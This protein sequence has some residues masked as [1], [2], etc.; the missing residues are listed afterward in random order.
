MLYL[1]FPNSLFSLS[2]PV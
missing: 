2:K 1:D